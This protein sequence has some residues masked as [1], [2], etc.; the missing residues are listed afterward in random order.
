M[1]TE[2]AST[3]SQRMLSSAGQEAGQ[4]DRD[5]LGDQI[6]GLHPAHLVGRDA[7]RALD[8]RQRGR[9]DL[10][11]EDRH[12]HAD[13]HR[14]EADPGRRRS[15]RDSAC[16]S[17]A[18]DMARS[19]EA[20]RSRRGCGSISTIALATEKTSAIPRQ[21]EAKRQDGDLADDDEVVRMRDDTGRGRCVTSGAPG[22][23]D[24][25]CRPARAKRHQ[26]PDPQDLQ[27][28]EDAEPRQADRRC[29]GENPQPGEPERV[30]QH[31]HRIVPGRDLDGALGQQRRGVAARRARARPAARG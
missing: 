22:S 10:H 21:A 14:R 7:E 11:V 6:G 9:H 17:G 5:D 23:D 26:H 30:Q 15:R 28:Q 24:D 2:T 13:A 20:P 25:P 19:G 16:R 3:N 29:P 31:D 12:E 8:R 18:F 27:R 4:R 1:K